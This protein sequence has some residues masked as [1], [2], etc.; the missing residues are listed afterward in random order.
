MPSLDWSRD[1][2][3][4][5][6]R[7]EAQRRAIAVATLVR[8]PGRVNLIGEH[9]DYNG[10]PVMPMA[11]DRDV[12]IAVAPRSDRRISLANVGA[13]QPRDFELSADITPYPAGDWG[14]YIK[15]AAQGLARH[16]G[17]DLRHGA[18]LLVDGNVPTGAGLSSSSAL[19]V[20]AA[21]SLLA[22]NQ[23][24]VP[25]PVLAELLPHAERYVGTMSGGMDQTI[26]LLGQ[27]GHALRID[28][29]PLRYRTVPLPAGYRF[30][31]SHSLV[32]AEKSGDAKEAYNRRVVECRIGC[33]LL[34]LSLADGTALQRL[35]DLAQD[36][37]PLSGF[38]HALELRLP[39][40]PM[41]EIEI[42]RAF[43]GPASLESELQDLVNRSGVAGPFQ[44]V[45]RVRH[46]LSEAD[47]VCAAEIALCNG[48]VAAFAE[49]MNDSHRSCRDDYQ[50]S[51]PELE[52]LVAIARDNGAIGAR[53]T[54]A[55]FGGCTVSLVPQ[56]HVDHLL[57]TLDRRFYRGRLAP[58]ELTQRR[59]SLVP[60]DGAAVHSL[61]SEA[62]ASG[63]P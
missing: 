33:R 24:E 50:I 49:R 53:L 31:V 35:G 8:A 55:G 48:D 12:R 30:V 4:R 54:G 9:T 10:L 21:L 18:D 46:V 16:C 1:E 32:A 29:F 43:G 41:T 14:N 2:R 34:E 45:R 6:L 57:Q 25:Y 7:A 62:D 47:R 36:D 20:A 5:T 26:S 56:G 40:Q 59:F 60:V 51:C 15:A 39:D 61:A 17:S 3:S 28:F 37:R 11:I 19:V 13:F 23:L 63:N 44:P 27:A 38:V 52:A 58:E 22:A 42:A